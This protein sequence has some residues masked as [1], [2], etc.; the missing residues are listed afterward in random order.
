MKIPGD[1]KRR[2]KRYLKGCVT[3]VTAVEKTKMNE[4]TIKNLRD[5][6]F[7]APESISRAEQILRDEE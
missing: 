4:K 7:A 1:L 2:W 3:I 6:K 5:G